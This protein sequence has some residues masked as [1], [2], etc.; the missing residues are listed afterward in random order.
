MEFVGNPQPLRPL[1]PPNEA[2]A[3]QYLE[4][5]RWPD[6]LK[7]QFLN[8]AL[9]IPLRFVIVD[10]SGSMAANDSQRFLVH[11]EQG[12]QSR[13]VK[14]SRWKELT[15]SMGFFSTLAEAART[16]TEFRLLNSAPPIVLGLGEDNGQ[17]YQELRRHLDQSPG[18]GTPLCRHISEVVAQITALE[19]QLRANG[20]KVALIIATDGEA[21][22][23]TGAVNIASVMAPLKD[24]PVLVIIRLCTDAENIVNYWNTIDSQLELNLEVLDDFESEAKNV[25]LVND[26]FTYCEPIHRIRELGVIS[27]ELDLIDEALLST[28]QMMA[29]VALLLTSGSVSDMPHPDLDWQAFANFVNNLNST[30]PMVW[31]P[32]KKSLQPRINM[33]AL[34]QK[35][36]L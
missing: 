30:L 33:A 16:P 2:S 18:G 13:F 9:K 28:D 31:C 32:I 4:S 12:A 11:G 34:A 36:H 17:K 1:P 5:C 24:L 15:E 29:V 25:A 19:P 3:M 10:D 14:C 27:K 7:T 20:Q 26:W 6:G 8:S 21:S 35:Y 23:E 22:D